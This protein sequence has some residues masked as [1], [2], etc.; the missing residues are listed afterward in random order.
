MTFPQRKSVVWLVVYLFLIVAAIPVRTIRADSVP[1]TATDFRFGYEIP[2]RPAVVRGNA[3]SVREE[4]DFSIV[5]EPDLF[6]ILL[7]AG[8]A[9]GILC[10]VVVI[11]VTV[12]AV[13]AGDLEKQEVMTA[14]FWIISL[15]MLLCLLVVPPGLPVFLL[16]LGIEISMAAVYARW[17]NRSMPRLLVIVWM[18]NLIPL[19]ILGILISGQLISTPIPGRLM[20]LLGIPVISLIDACI[21]AAAMRKEIRFWEALLLS[22]VLNAVGIGVEIL[23]FLAFYGINFLTTGRW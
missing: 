17:R 3:L 12:S 9:L 15:P 10:I 23:V 18:M 8:A 2:S 1:D 11:A 19:P 22:F 13:R 20:A 6:R 5:S 14:A 7:I 4:K 16:I 21:L